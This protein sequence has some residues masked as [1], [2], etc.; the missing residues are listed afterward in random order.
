M[1]AKAMYIT[2]EEYMRQK[3]RERE[4]RIQSEVVALDQIRPLSGFKFELFGQEIYFSQESMKE[5]A[6]KFLGSIPMP[7][8]TSQPERLQQAIINV[9]IEEEYKLRGEKEPMVNLVKLTNDRGQVKILGV[10]NERKPVVP[11]LSA[12]QAMKSGVGKGAT[13]ERCR[14]GD[15][16]IEV[17]YTSPDVAVEPRVGDV[18]R[19][20]VQM[21][22]SDGSIQ[23]PE[24]H[25]YCH[26]L[27]CQNGAIL[28][29]VGQRFTLVGKTTEELLEEIENVSAQ[30]MGEVEDALLRP[31]A[32]SVN[33]PV[34]DP[35]AVILNMA[36]SRR[37]PKRLNSHLQ[38]RVLELEGEV[39]QYDLINVLTS[40]QHEE[41]LRVNDRIRVQYAGGEEAHD[42]YRRC[43]SC[44]SVLN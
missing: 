36:A 19:G 16:G 35:T 34:E 40:L 13:L 20:G 4:G 29:V 7:F 1:T 38:S 5:F 23:N 21:F 43:S 31:L 15:K 12:V 11:L 30:M 42:H 24:I 44:H 26:R 14:L 33:H 41:G 8:Y 32:D 28:M 25:Y 6:G 3:L 37:L 9:R 2:N 39:T 27:V 22:Y 17:S 18:V 10:P